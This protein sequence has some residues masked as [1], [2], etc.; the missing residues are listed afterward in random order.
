MTTRLADRLDRIVDSGKTVI[1]VEHHRAVIA[2]AGW[3]IDMGP[4]A[5]HDGGRVVFEGTPSRL[6][7]SGC[8][9]TGQHPR[10]YVCNE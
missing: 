6:V 3:I 7:E 4:G 5:S 1:V 2:H 8:S 10:R 9:L